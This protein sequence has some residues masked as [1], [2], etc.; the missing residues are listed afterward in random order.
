VGRPE[1]KEPLGRTVRSK[2]MILKGVSKNEMRK[3]EIDQA[4]D[5]NSCRALVNAAMNI[6]FA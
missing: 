6:W 5:R 2:S 3:H 1:G 4:Q